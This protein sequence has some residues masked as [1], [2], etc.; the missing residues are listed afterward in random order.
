M[1][2]SRPAALALLVL[3]ALLFFLWRR[4]GAALVVP[5]GALAWWRQVA[6]PSEMD[7]ARP[8]RPPLALICA[9]VITLWLGGSRSRHGYGYRPQPV[10]SAMLISSSRY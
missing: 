5:T 2:W 10:P 1:A 3:P 9:M 8:R 4:G 6:R 7:A